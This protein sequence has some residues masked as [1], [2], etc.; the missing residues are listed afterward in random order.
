MA[1]ARL[2]A[3]AGGRG[4]ES[5]REGPRQRRRRAGAGAGVRPG[6]AAP[7]RAPRARSSR[8]AHSP[9]GSRRALPR[10]PAAGGG[11]G[12]R[13]APELRGRTREC[14]RGGPGR[15]LR[16]QLGAARRD[17]LL[18]GAAPG[19]PRSAPGSGPSPPP[20]RCTAAVRAGAAM[21]SAAEARR[22]RARGRRR[23][24]PA[25]AGARSPACAAPRTPGPHARPGPGPS[26]APFAPHRWRPPAHPGTGWCPRAQRERASSGP[27]RRAGGRPPPR[28]RVRLADSPGPFRTPGPRLPAAWHS[29]RHSPW[30]PRAHCKQAGDGLDAGRG[31]TECCHSV[32]IS[33]FSYSAGS[34]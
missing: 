2:P 20:S 7:R 1:A 3:Q 13:P 18:G 8:P 24:R 4:S 19:G 14:E 15:L 31:G 33:L 27:L 30:A 34:T 17:P 16:R 11:G 25:A 23:R 26:L 12:A 9:A 22:A 28:P 21:N 29:H 6:S 10:P 5:K 32:W